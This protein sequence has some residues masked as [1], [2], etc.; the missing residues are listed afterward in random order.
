MLSIILK[1]DLEINFSR[2]SYQVTDMALPVYFYT[3]ITCYLI[4]VIITKVTDLIY[5]VC[6]YNSFDIKVMQK[7]VHCFTAMAFS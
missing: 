3:S 1:N 2:L 6:C 5:L 4:K 7:S